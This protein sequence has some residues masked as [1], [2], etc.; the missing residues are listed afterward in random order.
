[1]PTS[2]ASFVATVKRVEPDFVDLNPQSGACLRTFPFKM[3]HF[4]S[5][6]ATV[7]FLG[8]NQACKRLKMH[9]LPRVERAKKDTE[10][11]WMIALSKLENIS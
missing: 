5:S 4:C 2:F 9:L 6:K 11:Y 3:L 7:W 10:P 8:T 1:V